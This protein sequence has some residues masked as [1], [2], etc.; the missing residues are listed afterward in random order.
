MKDG[1]AGRGYSFAVELVVEDTQEALNNS[2]S[3]AE[4]MQ[5][6]SSDVQRQTSSAARRD[7]GYRMN[8]VN[9][10]LL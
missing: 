3:V 4:D 6:T 9:L 8:V 7:Q 2:W 10:L 1:L 5:G